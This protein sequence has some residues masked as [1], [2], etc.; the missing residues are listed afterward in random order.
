VVL[1]LS[2]QDARTA[3]CV[4]VHEAGVRAQRAGQVAL[5]PHASRLH[6][7][8]ETYRKELRAAGLTG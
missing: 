6:E 3:A 7:R 4:S 8:H 5:R 2:V 1:S